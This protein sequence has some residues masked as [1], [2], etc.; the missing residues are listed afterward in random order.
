MLHDREALIS[1][2]PNRVFDPVYVDRGITL[3]LANQDG[4]AALL[5]YFHLRVLFYHREPT[6]HSCKRFLITP[7]ASK[8][9]SFS[10]NGMGLKQSLLHFIGYRFSS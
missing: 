2:Q 5:H 1:L 10:L 3:G 4:V 6:G 8:I 9:I 7:V